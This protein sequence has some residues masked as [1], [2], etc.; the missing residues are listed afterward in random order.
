MRRH[1]H[2][3]RLLARRA[4][5]NVAPPLARAALIAPTKNELASDASRDEVA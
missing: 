1:W 5:V 4:T 3:L 2:K